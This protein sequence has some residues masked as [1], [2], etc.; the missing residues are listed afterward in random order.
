M[1]NF[2]IVF[3]RLKKERGLSNKQI[4]SFTGALLKDIKKWELG[5][6]IP[7]DKKIIAALEG[8]LGNEISSAIGNLPNENLFKKE[9]SNVENSIFDVQKRKEPKARLGFLNRFRSGIAKKERNSQTEMYTYEDFSEVE[10]KEISEIDFSE[11]VYEDA[12]E[13]LPY[14]NDPKQLGFYFSRNTKTIFFVLIFFYL[15]Y[16]GL[17]LVWESLKVILDNLL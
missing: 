5:V 17:Q 2:A 15:S 14:I 12:V 7:T 11:G 1:E 8:I 9:I 3:S 16:Q 6:G 13:E 4:A 10:L